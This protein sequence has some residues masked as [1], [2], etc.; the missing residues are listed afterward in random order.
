M[1]LCKSKGNSSSVLRY[2]SISRNPFNSF[3]KNNEDALCRSKTYIQQAEIGKSLTG[4]FGGN[5]VLFTHN[6]TSKMTITKQTVK[7]KET[8]ERCSNER[9]QQCALNLSHLKEC[10]SLQIGPAEQA[11][12]NIVH[13]GRRHR[14]RRPA[15][16]GKKEE[17][18]EQFHRANYIITNSS[19]EF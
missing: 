10:E 9:S 2:L 16:K 15:K 19:W 8:V 12:R 3:K 18:V 1:G 17:S 14:R 7:Y 6:E 13:T 11:G 4:T 5:A